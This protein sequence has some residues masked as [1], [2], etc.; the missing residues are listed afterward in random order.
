MTNYIQVS[1]NMTFEQDSAFG[2]FD[3]NT[4][5]DIFR[6]VDINFSKA[7]ETKEFSSKQCIISY[8]HYGDYPMCCKEANQHR[9]YLRCNDD[10][11]CQWMFQFAHE[12]CH[13]LID[14][15]LSGEISGL[16]WFE[17]SVCEMSSM[18]HLHNLALH[19]QASHQQYL[20]RYAPSVRDYLHERMNVEPQLAFEVTHPGFLHKW[21]HILKEPIYHREHYK[22]IASLMLPLFL[23]NPH[24]WKIIL[25]FE[26]MRSWN[27]IHELFSHLEQTATPDYKISLVE[28]HRLLLCDIP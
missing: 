5:F 26:D 20:L 28:L 10:Y 15:K 6:L 25:H 22:A 18:Y 17:E 7:L 14:G 12:Y 21:E 4:I 19:Y 8:N 3:M 13:H 11:W 24:L 27:S 9:I 23:D 2:N 1:P 16:I